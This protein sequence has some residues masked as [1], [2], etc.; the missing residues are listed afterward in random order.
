[1]NASR[2]HFMR[3]PDRLQL[4][5]VNAYGLQVVPAPLGTAL[6]RWNNV[7]HLRCRSSTAYVADRIC[8]YD[9]LSQLLPP[10]GRTPLS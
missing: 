5:A 9:G 7:I 2:D 4:V 10:L 1:M 6:E 8:C 3:L